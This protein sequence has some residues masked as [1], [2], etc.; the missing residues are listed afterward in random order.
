MP[1]ESVT[2]PDDAR[3]LADNR[4]DGEEAEWELQDAEAGLASRSQ[5]FGGGER[6]RSSRVPGLVSRSD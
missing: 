4:W 2:R 5:R 3:Y 6:G 1:D